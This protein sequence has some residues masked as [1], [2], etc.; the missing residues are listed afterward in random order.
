MDISNKIDDPIL[1]RD[2]ILEIL[3]RE[4]DSDGDLPL[5]VQSAASSPQIDHTI[6]FWE[7]IR[8]ELRS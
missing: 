2:K 3:D 1:T 8:V 7:A 6:D 4:L 5:V